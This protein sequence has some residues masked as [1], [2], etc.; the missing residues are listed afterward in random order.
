M[1]KKSRLKN[2]YPA[3]KPVKSRR[4]LVERYF[5]FSWIKPSA[6]IIATKARDNQRLPFQKMVIM[7]A[8]RKPRTIPVQRAQSGN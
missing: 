7:G 3:P 8:I 2:A 6:T 1:I 5:V 4:G